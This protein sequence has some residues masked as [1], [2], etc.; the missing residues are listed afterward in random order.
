MA[1]T[2]D[3]REGLAMAGNLKARLRDRLAYL[4]QVTRERVISDALDALDRP[5]LLMVEAGAR[6]LNEVDYDAQRGRL[7]GPRD[8]VESVF[9]RMVDAGRNGA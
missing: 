3:T 5:T 8:L 4:D 9:S 2:A 1:E 7:I 6:V